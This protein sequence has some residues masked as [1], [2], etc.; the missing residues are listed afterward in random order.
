MD[1]GKKLQ[2]VTSLAIINTFASPI[3]GNINNDLQNKPQTISLESA[4]IKNA[5]DVSKSTVKIRSKHLV[6]LSKLTNKTAYSTTHTAGT[7]THY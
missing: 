3:W 7:T 6:K 2:I 4:D 5:R 1:K